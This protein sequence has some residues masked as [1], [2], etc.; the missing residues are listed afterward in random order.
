MIRCLD[1]LPSQ[2]GKE[3][4]NHWRHWAKTMDLEKIDGFKVMHLKANTARYH[5]YQSCYGTADAK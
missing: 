2:E 1:S 4:I 5:L 3:V